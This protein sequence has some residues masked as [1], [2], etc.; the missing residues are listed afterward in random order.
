MPDL[1]FRWVF[2]CALE[3]LNIRRLGDGGV[4][5]VTK[6]LTKRLSEGSKYARSLLLI[7]KKEDFVLHQQRADSSTNGIAGDDIL[8][9]YA[10]D[11]GS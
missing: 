8:Q 6:N 9:R 11:K 5:R 1:D 10:G 2:R 7:T 4:G 3:Y